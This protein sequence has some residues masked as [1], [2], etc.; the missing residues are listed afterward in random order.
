MLF[1]LF[2]E[3]PIVFGFSENIFNPVGMVINMIAGIGLERE[4]R[5]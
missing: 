4:Q 1:I 3:K 5:N 2:H